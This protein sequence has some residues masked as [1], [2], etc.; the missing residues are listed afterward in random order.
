MTDRPTT[1]EE[2]DRLR[3]FIESLLDVPPAEIQH[4][5]NWIASVKEEAR[6]LLAE[7]EAQS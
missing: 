4:P 5:E 7:L 3:A 2:R 1:R 6:A